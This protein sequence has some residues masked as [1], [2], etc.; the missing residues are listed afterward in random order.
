[1]DDVGRQRLSGTQIQSRQLDPTLLTNV[2]TLL[3]T[4][5]VT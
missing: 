4:I 2:P 1:L 3:A 5:T